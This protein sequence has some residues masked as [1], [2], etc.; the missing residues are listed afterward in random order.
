MSNHDRTERLRSTFSEDAELYHR[1]RP[2]YPDELLDDLQRVA[3]I[4][5]GCRVLE[6][7][8][9]TGQLTTSLA[10]RGCEIIGLDLGA[11]TVEVARRN[12]GQ[13]PAVNV[14]QATF[15]DWALPNTPFDVVVSATAFHWLDPA[16]RATKSAEAL[17]SGGILAVIS[18]HH[19]AGGDQGFFA[20]VQSCYQTWYGPSKL[21]RLP[22]A[23]EIIPDTEEFDRSEKFELPNIYRY[24]WEQAYSAASYRELLLT[25]SD[26]RSLPIESRQGLMNC[27]AELIDSKYNGSIKKR[28]MTQLI[29]LSRRSDPE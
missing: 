18:T 11:N 15:E 1:A 17:H 26:H 25:Y 5:Q 29:T 3:G 13:Y 7:G 24:E 10:E 28:H 19:I 20:D 12:L 8:C 27:I 14:Y 6:I 4:G 23:N 21:F 16:I 2:G 9:G 22:S